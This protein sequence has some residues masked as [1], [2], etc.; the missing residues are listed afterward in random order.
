MGGA[1]S[2]GPRA[3]VVGLGIS[4]I[5]TATALHRIG[6]TP[7]VVEKAPTRRSGGYFVGLFGAGRAAA[8]KLGVLGRLTNRCPAV[9]ANF[10]IDRAGNRWP[11]RSFADAPVQPFLMLR[12]DVEQAAFATLD[13]GVEVRYGT[14]PTD[15]E[16]DAGG[17][18]VTLAEASADTTSTERFDLVV[19][20]DGLRSTVRKLAFGPDRDH[21]HRMNYMIAAY[22]LPDLLPGFAQGEG[23][24]LSEEG[25]SFHAFPFFD[26]P[27]TAL[28]SYRTDDVDAEFTAKP[29]ERLRAVYG[30][31]PLGQPL[32]EALA[33]LE[34]ADEFL[35]DSV[36]QVS[37]DS[38]HRGRVV[39]VG[40]AAWCPTL[41]SGMG[42]SA[43][44]A[45]AEALGRVL[46]RHPDDL[47]RALSEWE[48]TLRPYMDY[49]QGIGVRNRSF[50][51]PADGAERR[52]RARMMRWQR[53][54]VVRRL[55]LWLAKRSKAMRMREADIA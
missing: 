49:Y 4:G 19:G 48:R 35:F 33:V 7:V 2:T 27:P 24:I 22:E 47:E 44:L 43:G 38:W 39:L 41:Y 30:P 42:V 51:T 54:P 8:E 52:R 5:A 21:L 14:V 55:L 12:G 9:S 16:Q 50:F 28:W 45:G 20:A 11:G 53:T 36:E 26:R 1:Q 32:E 3:L 40:D 15:I 29:S 31:E 10:E 34:S 13:E 17:V 37:L 25:R 6:W 46:Q 23:A 18:E